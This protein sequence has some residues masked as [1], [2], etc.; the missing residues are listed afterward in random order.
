MRRIASILLLLF[1]FLSLWAKSIDDVLRSKALQGD[2]NSCLA[3]GNEYF[4]G[5]NRPVNLTLA[6]YWYRKAA[7][8]PGV[9]EALFNL[10]VCYLNGWGIKLSKQNAFVYLNKAANLGNKRAIF[11]LSKLYFD[12][13]PEEED[14][15]LIIKKAILPNPKKSIELLE[16]LVAENYPQ[17][18]STLAYL[19]YSKDEYKSKYASY[20]RKLALEVAK[21]KN[22]SSKDLIFASKILSQGLGGEIN[23]TLSTEFLSRAKD[24]NDATAWGL[25]AQALESGLGIKPNKEEAIKLY[26]KA[27]LKGDALSQVKLGQY[28]LF[29]SNNIINPNQ[30]IELF[31]KATK[32][33]YGPAFRELGFCYSAGI[34]VERNLNQAFEYYQKAASFNDYLSFVKLGDAYYNGIGTYKDI[35]IALYWYKKATLANVVE[36]IRKYGK[37][38][39]ISSDKK[40]QQQGMLLINKAA[41]LGDEEAIA[42]LEDVNRQ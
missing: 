17:S 35:K 40:L 14:T 28:Y 36:G 18:K 41:Q 23:L 3:L 11:Y 9:P 33:N 5:V 2:K 34:G 13:I 10:G 39:L 32:Q 29:G 1:V 21:E 20:I 19:L 4:F 30:A 12:G 16:K 15:N 37:L 25:Y 24:M 27:A 42:I 31:F 38:L 7:V 8:D 22:A 26:E 6:V